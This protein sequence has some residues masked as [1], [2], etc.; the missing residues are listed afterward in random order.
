M[1]IMHKFVNKNDGI[2]VVVTAHTR[3]YAVTIYDTDSG[4]YFPAAQIFPSELWAVGVAKS[5]ADG[6]IYDHSKTVFCDNL[7]GQR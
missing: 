4:K 3:G 5:I 1:G 6:T 7:R 2:E